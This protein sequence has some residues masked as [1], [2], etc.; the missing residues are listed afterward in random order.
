MPLIIEILLHTV[1]G[2]VGHVT[3]KAITFGKIDLD[4][5]KSSESILTEA[6]GAGVLLAFIFILTFIL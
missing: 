3:V 1:C 5:G 4:W 6:I 2:W